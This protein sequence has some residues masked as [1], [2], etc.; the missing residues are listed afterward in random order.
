MQDAQR[1]ATY[2]AIFDEEFGVQTVTHAGAEDGKFS[3]RNQKRL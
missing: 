3:V 2:S 1:R